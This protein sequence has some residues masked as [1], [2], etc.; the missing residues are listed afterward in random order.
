MANFD[1]P[2]LAFSS[3]KGYGEDSGLAVYVTQSIDPTVKWDDI[4]WLKTIT[5][6]PVVLKGILRGERNTQDCDCSILMHL[7]MTKSDPQTSINLISMFEKKG[8]KRTT[9]TCNRR[10]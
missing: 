4:A 1:S 3:K 6:L 5:Y 10:W 9:N 7:S 2:D 8:W